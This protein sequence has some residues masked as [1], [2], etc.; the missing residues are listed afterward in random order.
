MITSKAVTKG[1]E[2]RDG[3][4]KSKLKSEKKT[5][6][7]SSRHSKTKSDIPGCQGGKGRMISE[8]QSETDL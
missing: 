2:L 4:V 6:R 3:T 5:F 8:P 7:E 1:Q